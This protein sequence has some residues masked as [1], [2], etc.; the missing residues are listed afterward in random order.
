MTCYASYALYAFDEHAWQSEHA[1]SVLISRDNR[2]RADALQRQLVQKRKK[3]LRPLNLI[4]RRYPTYHMTTRPQW[5]ASSEKNRIPGL[6][7]PPGHSKSR[8]SEHMESMGREERWERS[9]N[10]R[11][12]C[13]L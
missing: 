13:V 11:F 1:R 9:I 7:R 12:C 8:S 5:H 4:I 3:F 10:R 2:V 6:H